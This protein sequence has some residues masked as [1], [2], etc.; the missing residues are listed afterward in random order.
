M[1]MCSCYLLVLLR[2][3]WGLNFFVLP[4]VVRFVKTHA[5]DVVRNKNSLN[6]S[7][8]YAFVRTNLCYG[9]VMRMRPT[10]AKGDLSVLR[11]VVCYCV[12]V[13]SV[14]CNWVFCVKCRKS[15]TEMSINCNVHF[16]YTNRN[17]IE[18]MLTI[19]QQ[20]WCFWHGLVSIS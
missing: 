7:M 15:N 5:Q 14:Q 12:S 19:T 4:A 2:L 1:Y 11:Y 16:K 10:M 6:N 9:T 20:R 17:I 3:L 8:L 13:V 18:W